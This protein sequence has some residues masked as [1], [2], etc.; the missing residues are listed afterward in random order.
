MLQIFIYYIFLMNLMKQILNYLVLFVLYTVKCMAKKEFNTEGIIQNEVMRIITDGLGKGKLSLEDYKRSLN[1]EF[2]NDVKL[3]TQKDN[4]VTVT[5]SNDLRILALC[6]ATYTRQRARR[7]GLTE[8][9]KGAGLWGEII[10]MEGNLAVAA[11]IYDNFLEGLGYVAFGKSDTADLEIKGHK[12]DVKT[13]T[14][15]FHRNLMIDKKQWTN[16]NRT[17]DYYVGCTEP[18]KDTIRIWGYATHDDVAR[19]IDEI[20]WA[21]EDKACPIPLERLRDI[22]ELKQIP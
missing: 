15:D 8:I 6:L 10:G 18:T 12:V 20:G 21:Y 17:F 14:K 3:A 4:T 7:A 13:G 11:Y 1:G 19:F 16:P 2:I 22:R 5:L 9:F